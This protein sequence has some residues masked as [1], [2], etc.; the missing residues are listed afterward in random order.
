MN[1]ARADDSVNTTNSDS[2]TRKIRIG[3]SH[4]FLEV[5]KK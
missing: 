5:L 4:H 2:K 3:P 1:G